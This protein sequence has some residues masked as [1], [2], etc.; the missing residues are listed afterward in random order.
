MKFIEAKINPNATLK[1]LSKRSR[2]GP[3]R[4]KEIALKKKEEQTRSRVMA[5]SCQ[6]AWGASAAMALPVPHGMGWPC[7]ISILLS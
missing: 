3:P 5:R 2:R 1:M 6:A 7:H 4:M